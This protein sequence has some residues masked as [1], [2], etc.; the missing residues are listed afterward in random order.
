M[1]RRAED[2]FYVAKKVR[3]SGDDSKR[4]NKELKLALKTFFPYT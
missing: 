3:E 2:Y 1:N 4:E